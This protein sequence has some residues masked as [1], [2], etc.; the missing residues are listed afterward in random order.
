MNYKQRNQTY[1]PVINEFAFTP[2][3]IT[4]SASYMTHLYSEI[5][6][7]IQEEHAL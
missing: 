1:P 5:I 6:L 4:V 3:I 7:I 2:L